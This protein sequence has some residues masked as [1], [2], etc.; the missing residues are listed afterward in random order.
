MFIQQ[1][2]PII[3]K[4]S[5]ELAYI[6]LLETIPTTSEIYA[7]AQSTICLAEARIGALLSMMPMQEMPAHLV[8]QAAYNAG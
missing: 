8:M 7:A 2:M 3:R 1:Y 6:D 4:I 5:E